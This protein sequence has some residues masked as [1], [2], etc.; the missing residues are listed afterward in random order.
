MLKAA[1]QTGDLPA[2]EHNL[3][4]EWGQESLYKGKVRLFTADAVEA[5]LKDALQALAR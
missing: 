2:A 1:L 3:T 4:A 5:L